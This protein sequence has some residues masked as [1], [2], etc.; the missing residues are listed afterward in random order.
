[1]R[2]H[3]KRCSLH[4]IPHY[5]YICGELF[6]STFYATRYGFPLE[7]IKADGG[8]FFSDLIAVNFSE[9]IK[10]EFCKKQAEKEFLPLLICPPPRRHK[11][12]NF[13]QK[14][15]LSISEKT[16][17]QFLPESFE[18]DTRNR[19]ATPKPTA[20][21]TATIKSRIIILFDDVATTAYTLRRI[22]EVLK[23]L[24]F[25]S[26]YGLVAI[27]NRSVTTPTELLRGLY[28]ERTL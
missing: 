6:Y 26:I 10:Y 23:S 2:N 20:A 13:A 28:E 4:L 25:C 16:G 12:G 8:C 1:M 21:L 15:C 27:D 3:N 24:G 14:V 7:E 19:Y 18:I 5:L 9:Y 17:V 22:V 11:R